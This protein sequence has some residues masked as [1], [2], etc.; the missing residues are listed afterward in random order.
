MIVSDLDGTLLNEHSVVSD[1]TT[2]AL[3]EAHARGIVIVAATGRSIHSA[4]DLLRPS[5]VVSWALCSNGATLFDLEN[6]TLVH[7]TLI[8]AAD[9]E[10]FITNTRATYETI[11]LAWETETALQWDQAYQ[12]HRDSLVPRPERQEGRIAPFPVGVDLV[13]LLVTHPER[14]HD[15]WLQ[16]LTPTIL[17]SMVASTSGTD[18]VEITHATATK[19][20]AIARLC[21]ELGIEQHQVAAFGDQVNDLDM[22]Q[23]AGRGYAMD[24]AAAAVKAVADEIA[25]HHAE[26]GVA[27]TISSLLDQR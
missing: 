4:L 5:E 10:R 13:K 14:T 16:D 24:N 25:P 26:H 12:D 15:E 7:N 9:V 21:A 23:W 17:P 18:F 27:Q 22:I 19:G 8:P 6:E 11:G 2:V 20:Q 3:K 1:E